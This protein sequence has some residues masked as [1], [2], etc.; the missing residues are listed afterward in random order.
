[1]QNY[2]IVR[3]KFY[4]AKEEIKALERLLMEARQR[5]RDLLKKN[6]KQGWWDWFWEFVGFYLLLSTISSFLEYNK[7]KNKTV[8]SKIKGMIAEANIT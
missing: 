2:V 6:N 8:N 3:D 1:M 5:Q 7:Y 4:I